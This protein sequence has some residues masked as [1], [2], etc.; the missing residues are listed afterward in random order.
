M[1]TQLINLLHSHALEQEKKFSPREKAF[2]NPTSSQTFPQLPN[3]S[4]FHK[5]VMKA[6]G[7]GA[8]VNCPI[9]ALPVNSCHAT[10]VPYL[11]HSTPYRGLPCHSGTL[12]P[13]SPNL[14]LT[15]LPTSMR[16][17]PRVPLRVCLLATKAGVAGRQSGTRIQ[18]PALRA[19]PGSTS[20]SI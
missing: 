9:A 20:P 3:S 13:P 11:P 18:L 4:Q 5:M 14:L 7:P 16:C 17:Q 6:P 12:L 1:Y 19:A 15:K 10:A 8:H 2:P